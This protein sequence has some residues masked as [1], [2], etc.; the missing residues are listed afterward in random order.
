M[1]LITHNLLT[2]KS[3][4][5]VING[6]PLKLVVEE[7]K[8]VE[9]EFRPEMTKALLPK[10]DYDVLRDAATLVCLLCFCCITSVLILFCPFPAWPRDAYEC[11]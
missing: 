6:Y 1:K 9:L 7:S 4:K 5:N 3:L 11:R 8:V 2:S 10:I